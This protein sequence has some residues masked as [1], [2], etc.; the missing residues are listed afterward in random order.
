MRRVWRRRLRAENFGGC[1]GR[2]TPLRA[3]FS[4]P[5]SYSS[6]RLAYADD[7]P[8]AFAYTTD[9]EPQ[10]EKEIEQEVTW[11]PAMRARLSR[12][13]RA[14]A[15]SNTGFTDNF[16][17]SFYLTYDWARARPHAPTWARGDLEPARRFGRVH[18]SIPQRLFR[19]DR[20]GTLCGA[21]HC[22][23]QPRVRAESAASK[24]LPQRCRPRRTYINAEDRWEKK[25]T[26]ALYEISALEFYSGVA[27]SLTPEWS[28]GLE[29][30]NERGFDG[31][32]L[33]GAS[34]Y[35]DNATFLGPVISYAGGR[36]RAALG[37]Q[38][39][40]PWAGRPELP[41]DLQRIPCRRGALS[42]A[43]TPRHRSLNR[44]PHMMKPIFAFAALRPFPLSL[45]ITPCR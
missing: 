3:R 38:A 31:L 41:R 44:E 30:G 10:Y 39:Q 1:R 20:A 24:E 16:Q 5:S 19:S 42:R 15:N 9:L 23:R 4:P 35:A 32:I 14:A 37:M 6:A 36:F 40:L 2:R 29:L 21:F 11:S 8:F 25:R 17:G 13:S 22:Q 7:P 26:G 33:G 45:R 27:Y 18:L 43:P 12:K 34:R 28:L